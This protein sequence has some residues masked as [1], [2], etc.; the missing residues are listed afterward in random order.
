[1]WGAYLN[2]R[3]T[4]VGDLWVNDDVEIHASACHDLFEGWR[5]N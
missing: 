2:D 4:V 1:M 5:T 3:L